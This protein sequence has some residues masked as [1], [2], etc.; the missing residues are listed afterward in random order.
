MFILK[1]RNLIM[2][3]NAGD[4]GDAGGGS[5]G[6]GDAGSGDA[7][8]G[9]GS[10]GRFTDVFTDQELKNNPSLQRF[11]NPESLS[12][13]YIELER[14]IGSNTVTVPKEGATDEEKA[15]FFQKIGRPESADKY[16]IELSKELHAGVAEMSNPESQGKYK[17]MAFGLGLLP[18]QAQGLHAWH[19]QNISD[20]LKQQEA[21]AVKETSDSEAALRREWGPTYDKNVELA[22]RVVNKF[23]GEEAQKLLEQSGLG[24]N[25]IMLKLLASAGD[26]LSE[27]SLGAGGLSEFGGMSVAAANAKKQE[28]MTD[29]THPYHNDGP[30]HKEAVQQVLTLNKII[31]GATS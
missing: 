9:S 2:D 14:K 21:A 25:P 7:G 15:S 18:E 5:G 20:A 26:K 24:R 12:K 13:S 17:E 8:F 29:Q 28:I 19:M 6:S 16:T 3:E 22:S 11:K 10:E 1:N 4:G 31:T 30:L 27:D 23:G